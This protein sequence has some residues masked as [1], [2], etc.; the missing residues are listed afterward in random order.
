MSDRLIYVR[1]LGVSA[2]LSADY[3]TEKYI[4]IVHYSG[5]QVQP[6]LGFVLCILRRMPVGLTGIMAQGDML[7]CFHGSRF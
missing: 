6:T 3:H 2:N 7:P 4:L 5:C 1:D